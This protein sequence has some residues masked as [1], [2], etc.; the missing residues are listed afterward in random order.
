MELALGF[1]SLIEAV[2]GLPLWLRV[3]GVGEAMAVPLGC[4]LK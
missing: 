1:P 4:K 2:V 3:E